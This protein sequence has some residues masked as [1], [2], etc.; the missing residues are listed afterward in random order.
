MNRIKSLG[1]FLASLICV[2]AL[3]AFLWVMVTQ[4]N[5]EVNIMV[6]LLGAV[7]F[8]FFLAGLAGLLYY[9]VR[10]IT[11]EEPENIFNGY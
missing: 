11:G 8:Y 3:P 9:P 5:F 2:A 10:F 4:P 7:G 6:V 1:Y